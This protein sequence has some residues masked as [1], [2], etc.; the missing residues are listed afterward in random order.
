MKH[1]IVNFLNRPNKVEIKCN[2]QPEVPLG[3][4]F[5]R[6]PPQSESQL[7]PYELIKRCQQFSKCNGCGTLFDKTDEKLYF[8]K[9]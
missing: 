6:K 2:N 4:S 9:E 5:R 7:Y 3:Q 1:Y 8:R